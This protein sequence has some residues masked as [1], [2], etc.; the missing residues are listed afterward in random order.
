VY[1][2]KEERRQTPGVMSR[3]GL[4]LLF[5]G[6]FTLTPNYLTPNYNYLTPNYY[7]TITPNYSRSP[8]PRLPFTGSLRGTG[9]CG[10]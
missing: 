6:V 8:V 4:P 9:R 5:C 10:L 1:A 7:P 2:P 3:R